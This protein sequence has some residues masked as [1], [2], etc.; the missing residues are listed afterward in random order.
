MVQPRD[1]RRTLDLRRGLYE[2]TVRVRDGRGRETRLVERRLVHLLEPHLA[3]QHLTIAALN[4]SGR[5]T[6]RLLLDGRVTNAGVPRYRPFSGMH[7]GV[8]RTV[9]LDPETVLLDAETTQSQLRITQAARIRI[10]GPGGRGPFERRPVIEPSRVGQEITLDLGAGEEAALEKVVAL[11]TSR[12]RASADSATEAQ[13]AVGHAGTFAELL[14]SQALA[15]AQL[16]RRCDLQAVHID[17]DAT[18]RTHLILR[19]HLFHLLQT[20]SPHTVELDAGIPARGW[21]G[22]GYRGHIFWDELFVFPFLVL[23]LPVLARALLLY[24]HR[25]LPEARRAARAAGYRGAMF[26]WQSGSNGREE[27][28]VMFLNPRSGRWIRDD[29]RLQRPVGAAVAYNV[30]QYYQATGDREFLATHGAEL[31]LEIARFWAS[32]ARWDEARGRY[33]IRGVLGPDEFHDRYPGEDAPGLNNN[34]Y[35]NVM[36]AWC[37]TRAL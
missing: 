8:L 10:A 30:W 20:V 23:R 4:W 13:A 19:L 3:G 16:W 17:A 11:C 14:A 26:P 22:E 18:H 35:T 9:A 33:A 21:H 7:L 34:A 29:T 25:R 31:L 2:R 36:A 1:C 12:D 27:T 37:L 15:W 6:L 24:R 28:D 32:I 5:L